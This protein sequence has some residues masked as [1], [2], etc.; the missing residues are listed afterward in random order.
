MEAGSP[1]ASNSRAP[2]SASPSRVLAA[3]V[4]LALLV[5]AGVGTGV[6]MQPQPQ[7]PVIGPHSMMQSK[8]PLGLH[9]VV[10][11]LPDIRFKR[12]FRVLVAPRSMRTMPSS[13][14]ANRQADQIR[15][16]EKF[17]DENFLIPVFVPVEKE[18]RLADALLQG[19][20]DMVATAQPSPVLSKRGLRTSVPV[21]TRTEHLVVRSGDRNLIARDLAGREIALSSRSGFWPRLNALRRVAPSLSVRILS[22]DVSP[23]RALRD[24][25]DMSLDLAV[26]EIQPGAVGVAPYSDLTIAQGFS[27][28]STLS[29]GL[30]PKSKEMR[31]ALDEFL[32]RERLAQ[33]PDERFRATWQDIRQR[34]LL[35]VIAR[36]NATSYFIWRGRPVG[37]EY[38]LMAKF[39][40]K[41]NLSLQMIVPERRDELLPALAEG[42]GDVVATPLAIVNGHGVDGVA[43]TRAYLK[44]QKLFV[45]AKTRSPIAALEDLAGRTVHVRRSAAS[46]HALEQLKASAHFELVAVPEDLETE[47]ILE[48]VSSGEYDV[49]V[50]AKNEIRV[51]QLWRDAISASLP[52]GDVEDFGWAVRAGSSELLAHL[53][54]FIEEEYRELEYNMLH[55]RYFNNTAQVRAHITQR[56]DGLGGGSLSPYDDLVQLYAEQHGFDWPLI[57][58]IM[59]RESRFDPKVISL[60]GAQGLMQVLPVTARRF[61]I[62]N[63]T[64]PE[65]SIAAGVRMLS[66][67]YRHL[68]PTLPVR[69][70]LWF[71][72]A[73][74]NAGLGHLKDARRLARRLDLDPDRWFDNVERAMLLLS[75]PEYYRKAKHGYV[76]GREPVAYVRDIRDLYDAYRSLLRS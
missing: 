11:D 44:T 67:L 57:V 28:V 21:T 74:Y 72:L 15:L 56:A 42:R 17:A 10:S 73:A 27:A 41:H 76:R 45:T 64:Q 7:A 70:R 66:W 2:W 62:T 61:G 46:W 53:N 13:S 37:F 51:A 5:V 54:Q 63:L 60:A 39:A 31:I 14:L 58:A 6:W 3:C 59:Y 16:I 22:D 9:A 8:R 20:G 65:N 71:S 50:A 32:T 33:R 55:T 23:E 30:H 12:E 52:L 36:N 4:F 43:Y 47:E 29:F 1:S 68:E 26:V 49:T 25:Q 48:R 18:S 34:G 35:R 40:R 69:E 19:H 75:K 24:V 38:E